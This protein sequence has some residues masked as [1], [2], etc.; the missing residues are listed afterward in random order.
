MYI[1]VIERSPST[2]EAGDGAVSGDCPPCLQGRLRRMRRRG[3][4]RPSSPPMSLDAE[5]P[6][7]RR[8]LA[9]LPL[10]RSPRG[11][12]NKYMERERGA[13]SKQVYLFRLQELYLYIPTGHHHRRCCRH[14]VMR[15]FP[16]PTPSS[17]TTV[18]EGN[19]KRLSRGSNNNKSC[20]SRE[21][22]PARRLSAGLP[23]RSL[24]LLPLLE[25]KPHGVTP[26]PSLSNSSEKK[27]R[28]R[29]EGR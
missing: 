15:R 27:K 1:C 17:T 14:S 13:K 22:A 7:L 21:T 3:R 24:S 12:A 26:P 4:R 28:G 11:D 25:Q 16:S 2:K 9:L 20:C 5:M 10:P 6:P 23:L 19:R 29:G 18:T 8:H